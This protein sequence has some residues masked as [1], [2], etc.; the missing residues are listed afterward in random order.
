[1]MGERRK[2]S[3]NAIGKGLS[4]SYNNVSG[5]SSGDLQQEASRQAARSAGEGENVRTLTRGFSARGTRCE[6]TIGSL[7]DSSTVAGRK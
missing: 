2:H 5:T 1:M 4:L 6:Q 3:R 7:F